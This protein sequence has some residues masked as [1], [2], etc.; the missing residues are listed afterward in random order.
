MPV[1]VR[2]GRKVEFDLNR[3]VFGHAVP[4]NASAS[5]TEQMGTTWLT[6]SV[7]MCRILSIEQMVLRSS[8]EQML[9]TIFFSSHPQITLDHPQIR[10]F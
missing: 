5:K 1:P 8:G 4:R 2:P 6:V 7:D 9:L 3:S 10:H